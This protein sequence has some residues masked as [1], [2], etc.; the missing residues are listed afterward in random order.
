MMSWHELSLRHLHGYP[1][2][3]EPGEYTDLAPFKL[4]LVLPAQRCARL[5]DIIRAIRHYQATRT[6]ELDGVEHP[7][8]ISIEELPAWF[9][10]FDMPWNPA[11]PLS[12][13]IVRETGE[14]LIIWYSGKRASEPVQVSLPESLLGQ[15]LGHLQARLDLTYY[16]IRRPGYSQNECLVEISNREQDWL[17]SIIGQVKQVGLTNHEE[18]RREAVIFRMRGDQISL[19]PTKHGFN[20]IAPI[21]DSTTGSE[22]EEEEQNG[23]TVWVLGIV[24]GNG[25]DLSILRDEEQ[26]A[27]AL[28]D[29]HTICMDVL[30]RSLLEIHANHLQALLWKEG[31]WTDHDPSMIVP[32]VER[33]IKTNNADEQIDETRISS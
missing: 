8:Q 26:A 25:I 4:W 19:V 33:V 10:R 30:T 22:S 1:P 15:A 17:L 16:A 31:I 27:L 5:A 29:P 20:F 9:E 3:G 24:D 28:H 7:P 2:P 14:Q 12:L 13:W 18:E 6:N 21:T 11:F 23:G 32:L